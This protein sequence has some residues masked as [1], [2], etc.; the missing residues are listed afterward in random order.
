MSQQDLR[1]LLTQLHA[2][3]GSARS[4]DADER[5]SLTTAL[6]DIEKV[7]A[8]SDASA[9]PAKPR[10]EALAVRFEAD[11]PALAESLRQLVDLLA[12]AGI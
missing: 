9:A 12:K 2:R 7:L 8:R 10:L 1:E 5:K 4:L 11:H 3:L 6:H